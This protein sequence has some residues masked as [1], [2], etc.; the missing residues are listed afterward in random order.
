MAVTLLVSRLFGIHFS[1]RLCW[2]VCWF[3]QTWGVEP[4]VPVSRT[5]AVLLMCFFIG[6][7]KSSKSLL[8]ARPRVTFVC[9]RFRA[10]TILLAA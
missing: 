4:E 10:T 3:K 8:L 9:V 7:R 1:A 2:R 6:F 5:E